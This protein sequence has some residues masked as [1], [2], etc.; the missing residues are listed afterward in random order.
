MTMNSRLL[1]CT[2]AC[3]MM[4]AGLMGAEVPDNQAAPARAKVEFRLAEETPG[5]GLVEMTDASTGKKLYMHKEAVITNEHIAKAEAVQASYATDDTWTATVFFAK[6][7]TRRIAEATGNN[8]G[9][10][11]GIVVDGKLIMA[12]IIMVKIEIDTVSIGSSL[13]S[14]EEA[15]SLAKKIYPEAVAKPREEK[16]PD[17]VELIEYTDEEYSALKAQREKNGM[18]YIDRAWSKEELDQMLKKG[19]SPE[20]VTRILGK[21]THVSVFNGKTNWSYELAPEKH[22]VPRKLHDSGA[23]L[24]FE[25]D[26]LV[27]WGMI[28]GDAWRE[29]R[30]KYPEQSEL[31]MT[32]TPMDWHKGNF[33]V[34]DYVKMLE[35][36][37][38][39][40][41]KHQLNLP[42]TH[43]ILGIV[44][45]SGYFKNMS[46][47][48]IVISGNGDLVKLLEANF[49]EVAQYNW[50]GKK[51][52]DRGKVE[53]S[54]LKDLLEPYLK[55][56]KTLPCQAPK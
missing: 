42:D 11:L 34:D 19:M 43:S 25:N 33:G 6:E 7:G 21:P 28:G 12:P 38:I 56:D 51:D 39:E 55:G 44:V 47:E 29:L 27:F 18:F 31:K 52:K 49:P 8:I 45:Q 14:K 2:V 54:K 17:G 23:T 3:V 32:F 36:I 46:G 50:P 5:D 30:R 41:T 37:K 35:S 4:V 10:A 48:D 13:Q 24:D 53:L 9:K 1:L 15:I 20:S 22:P 26:Q 16:L 40:D